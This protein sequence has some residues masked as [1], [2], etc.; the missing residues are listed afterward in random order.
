MKKVISSIFLSILT[1]GTLS[2]CRDAIDIVQDGEMSNEVTFQSLSDVQMFLIGNVY[3]SLDVAN[4]IDFASRFTDESAQGANNTELSFGTHQFFVDT[5][6]GSANG[7]W[8]SN[9]YTINRVNRMLEGV[10][11]YVPTDADRAKFN[12]YIAE[13]RAIRAYAYARIIWYFSPDPMDNNALGAIYV[14]GVPAMNN[15]SQRSNNGEIY[16]KIFEDL[17]FA[18]ANLIDHTGV[19]KKNYISK[20]AVNAI[21]AHVYLN[22]GDYANAGIFAEK[23]I[24]GSGLVLTPAVPTPTTAVAGTSAWHTALKANDSTNPY[25]KMW[26]DSNLA[27]N[28]IIFNLNRPA[29]VG[30]GANLSALF[31]TNQSNTTSGNIQYDMGRRLFNLLDA[32]KSTDI[33]RWV[34]IDPTSKILADYATNPNYLT[35][36]VLVID[37]YPGKYTGNAPL[38]NDAKVFRLSDMYLI[39]A[40]SAAHAS[41]FT[42]AEEMVKAV[43]DARTFNGTS[44]ELSY[45]SVQTA[46]VDILLER[47]LELAFEGHRYLDLKRAGKAAGVSIDRDATDDK[48]D[49]PLTLPIDDY[50]M[51][52]LP[53]P[54]NEVQ[55]NPTIQQNPG[56]NN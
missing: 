27:T 8:I 25:A 35:A 22:K 12:S 48:F 17:E 19:E 39:V 16:A 14:D 23:V 9:Y 47:R 24:A 3:S 34:Y 49:T 50:R 29:L 1:L 56:Y 51:R 46:L 30:S 28:E 36:E 44:P 45:A 5:D 43:R 55:G 26:N 38:R 52:S 37:K 42:K 13:A 20:D 10:K 41:N 53:I 33:R 32:R 54:K 11:T 7:M 21:Y 4:E 18:S 6:N 15:K 2:S 31:N 40:E